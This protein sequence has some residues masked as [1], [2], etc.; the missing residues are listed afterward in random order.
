MTRTV[1][2]LTNGIEYTF[3]V[4]LRNAGGY[5][6]A[7]RA[8]ATPGARPAAPEN[9]TA[10]AGDGRG[11]AVVAGSGKPV[12]HPVS[13]TLDGEARRPCR[14]GAMPISL[15]TAARRRRNTSWKV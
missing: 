3:E 7:S 13:G 11:D 2:D 12:Y 5:S 4:Q 9:L 6:E 10:S 15:T 8:T 14:S 1:E